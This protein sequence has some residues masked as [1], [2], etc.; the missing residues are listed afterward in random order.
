MKEAIPEQQAFEYLIHNVF[1][2][3]KANKI[4]ISEYVNY[5]TG[6]NEVVCTFIGLLNDY[7]YTLLV[8]IKKQYFIVQNMYSHN[9]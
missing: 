3:N 1:N 2:D 5:S 8:Q 6:R 4:N 9:I 7:D